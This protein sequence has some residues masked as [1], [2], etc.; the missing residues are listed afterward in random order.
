MSHTTKSEAVVAAFIDCINRQDLDGLAA[1]MT[2]DHRLHC[3]GQQPVC[4]RDASLAAWT[5]YFGTFPDYVVYRRQVSALGADVTVV[6][7]TTGS[8]RRLPP[9]EEMRHTVT[10]IAHVIDG[11]VSRWQ[12]GDD[13]AE[14]SAPPLSDVR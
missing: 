7:T 3:G 13:L 6:G 8:H 2:E 14:L 12:V 5:T 4:G 9:E 1:L 11:A 10:W